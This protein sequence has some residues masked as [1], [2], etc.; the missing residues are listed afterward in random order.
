[1]N[2]PTFVLFP[3]AGGSA[4]SYFLILETLKRDYVDFGFKILDLP[5][6]TKF[7]MEKALISWGELEGF[8]LKQLVSIG[9][10]LYLIGVSFGAIVAFEAAKQGVIG[11]V[12]IRGLVTVNSPSPDIDLTDRISNL[13]NNEKNLIDFMLDNSNISDRQ[14]FIECIYPVLSDALVSD[15]R[16]RAAWMR[17]DCHKLSCP[18]LSIYSRSDIRVGPSEVGGWRNYS[19]EES[20]VEMVEGRHIPDQQALGSV[21][22]LAIQHMS[23]GHGRY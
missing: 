23:S 5:G 6:R 10:P 1:M 17:H 16:L 2:R 21:V 14:N 12:D 9:G 8:L 18:I 3:H 22:S 19:C 7:S 13:L 11:G 4:L 15:L 20:W